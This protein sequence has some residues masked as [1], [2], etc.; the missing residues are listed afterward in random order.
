MKKQ[1]E[2]LRKDDKETLVQ[3]NKQLKEDNTTIQKGSV[4]RFG[5]MNRS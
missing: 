1:L 2:E 5:I 4:C 3:E